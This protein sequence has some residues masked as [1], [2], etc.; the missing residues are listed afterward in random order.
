MNIKWHYKIFIF[1]GVTTALGWY[2]KHNTWN[3]GLSLTPKNPSS[4]IA[5]NPRSA[6]AITLQ[7]GTAFSVPRALPAFSLTDSNH[8]LFSN[9]QLND[10]WTFL[11]FGYTRCESICPA[12]LGKLAE[13]SR[14]LGTHE[15]SD[16]QF[17]FVS[18]DPTHDTSTALN[19]Y[20]SSNSQFKNTPFLGVTGA[21]SDIQK[22]ASQIGL[23]VSQSNIPVNGHIEHSGT[24]LLINPDGKLAAVFSD[25][26]N[27]HAMARDLSSLMHYYD[28]Q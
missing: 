4:T 28:N 6:S 11:F 19:H 3:L 12:T 14:L 5:S 15:D 10:Y 17:V 7:S 13:L 26:T 8:K 20:F 16:T 18:I 21:H 23:F 9:K 25:T 22:L 24:V 27:P 1:I 2:L